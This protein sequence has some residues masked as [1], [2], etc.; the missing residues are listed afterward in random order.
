VGETLRRLRTSAG[1]KEKEAA[2]VIK[3][4][5]SKIS[6]LESGQ[7][8]FREPELRTLL[9]FYK[10]TDPA[11]RDDLIGLA[12]K[13]NEPG[14][15]DKWH[16]VCTNPLRTHVSLEEV[17][18]WIRSYEVAQLVGLL[19]IPDYAR[20][21][22]RANSPELDKRAV[23]R[24]VEL[25]TVRRQRFLDESDADLLCVLDEV[26]LARGYG[27]SETMRRQLDFLMSLADNPRI[28]FRLVPLNGRNLP[29]QSVGT[30]T[31]FDF[32]DKRLPSMVY[33][34]F[35]NGGQ[36]IEDPTRVDAHVKSFDRLGTAS[37]N[38]AAAVQKMRDYLRK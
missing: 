37:M 34:E 11:A 18:H 25:R 27:P 21:L 3:C 23:D 13:A 31:I 2:E 14:W 1:F 8:D 4:S 26:T 19:Q 22:V 6:R 30:T 24:I 15:W 38:Q 10:M 29:V 33:M 5:A 12:L 16:D 20:A 17:A 35:P 32:T 36:Y 28:T 7:H 9:D